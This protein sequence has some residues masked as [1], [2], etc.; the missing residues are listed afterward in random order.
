MKKQMEGHKY[1]N[2][3]TAKELIHEVAI[4]GI[5]LN[6]DDQC[7]AQDILGRSTVGELKELANSSEQIGNKFEGSTFYFAIQHLWNIDDVLRFWNNNS[8]PEHKEVEL[9]RDE[10]KKYREYNKKLTE[11]VKKLKSEIAQLKAK[12]INTDASTEA[13]KQEIL[14]LKAHLFDMM[15]QQGAA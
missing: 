1:D 10:A 12:A 9:L 4:N 6:L 3:K 5:S 2:I 15:E 11:E 13:Y 7:R 14:K 8:N